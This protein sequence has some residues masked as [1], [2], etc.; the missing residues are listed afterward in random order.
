MWA[1][2]TSYTYD[3]ARVNMVAYLEHKT[4][5]HLHRNGGPSKLMLPMSTRWI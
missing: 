1:L 3:V 4:K 5:S 2:P